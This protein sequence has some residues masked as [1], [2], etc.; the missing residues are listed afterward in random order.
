MLTKTAYFTNV[1]DF[2]YS[3]RGYGETYGDQ[4]FLEPGIYFPG[5][6]DAVNDAERNMLS[7]TVGVVIYDC[8]NRVSI[9]YYQNRS[10]W[11][12]RKIQ[13]LRSA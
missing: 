8:E 2:I 6:D 7:H 12:Q 5:Q 10:E 4:T 1:D 13:A 11:S 9:E 3:L